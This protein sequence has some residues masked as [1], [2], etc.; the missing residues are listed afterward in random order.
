VDTRIGVGSL[1]DVTAV[2][3]E[4]VLRSPDGDWVVFVE[5]SPGEFQP[6]EVEVRR[7]IQGL[8]VIEGVDPGDRVVTQGAFFVQSELAKSG[9]DIHAH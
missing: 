1:V 5:S 3:E 8:A 2:P 7:M 9:F 4:A 6:V